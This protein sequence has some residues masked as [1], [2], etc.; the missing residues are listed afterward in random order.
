MSQQPGLAT[1]P[2]WPAI[3]LTGRI[4]MLT[5]A[6]LLVGSISTEMG[7]SFE[8][9]LAV[10]RALKLTRVTNVVVSFEC[11]SDGTK[12]GNDFFAQH[13]VPSRRGKNE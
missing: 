4:A 5:L 6:R 8:A 1:Q 12:K 13:S 2:K 11:G 3:I 10:Q 7:G 9:D